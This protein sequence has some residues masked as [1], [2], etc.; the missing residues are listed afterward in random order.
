LYDDVLKI[1]PQNQMAI[2]GK[3]NA[4]VAKKMVEA[5]AGGGRTG[6]GGGGKAFVPGKTAGQSV[7]TK[8]GAVPDGFEDTGGIQ[9]KKASQNVDLPGKILFDIEPA[10]SRPARSTR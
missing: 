10:G 2:S 8:G 3:T 6:G 9:V 4:V 1:D 7:E 5:A